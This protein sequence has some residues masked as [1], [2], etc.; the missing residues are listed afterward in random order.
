MKTDFKPTGKG[1]GKYILA[2]GIIFVIGL[3]FK[4][5]V[6]PHLIG[7]DNPVFQLVGWIVLGIGI[8][9]VVLGIVILIILMGLG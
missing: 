2:F 3:F 8:T 1:I 4:L 9:G 6:E 7:G 5:V